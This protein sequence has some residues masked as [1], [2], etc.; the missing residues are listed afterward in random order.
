MILR[1][2]NNNARGAI[3]L[4]VLLSI[5][6]LTTS[7]AVIVEAM[8]TSLRASVTTHEYL[9]ADLLVNNAFFAVL[10]SGKV[11]CALKE[12]HTYDAYGRTYDVVSSTRPAQVP[13]GLQASAVNEVTTT[14]SWPSRNGKRTRAVTTYMLAD[15]GTGNNE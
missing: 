3:L 7:I 2:G 10:P 12:E 15:T 9:A 4:E 11:R 1:I 14:V 5:V 13:E 8:A 6:I